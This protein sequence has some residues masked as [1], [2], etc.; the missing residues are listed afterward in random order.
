MKAVEPLIIISSLS[1][2]LFALSPLFLSCGADVSPVVSQLIVNVGDSIQN[3]IN[4]ALEG[5]TIL[6]KKGTYIEES[7]P[8]IVNKTVVIV[9][10]DVESTIVDGDG[11]EKG[12]FLVKSNGVKIANL[13]IRNTVD[14]PFIPVAGVQLDDVRNVMV[15][16]CKIEMCMAGIM[17]K[18]SNETFIVRNIITGN[19]WAGIYLRG[20]CIYNMIVGNTIS[21]NPCG[22]WIADLTC[23]Y[24]K[25]YHNNLLN[26]TSQTMLISVGGAWDNGYPSGG[27]YWSNYKGVDEK[28]GEYQ[29]LSGGDGIGDTPYEGLD[30]YPLLGPVHTFYAG[31][32]NNEN[33][34]VVI[35]SNLVIANFSFNPDAGPFIKFHVVNSV[36]G[37]GFC[38]II[39]P[40]FLLWVEKKEEW[41]VRVNGEIIEQLLID[42]SE[43]ENT[44]FYLTCNPNVQSIEIWGTKA[45]PEFSTMAFITFAIIL[46]TILLLH[47]EKKIC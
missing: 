16:N 46:P 29:N 1:V 18:D 42:E 36:G 14:N 32:W 3:A 17:L 5:A 7:Y 28:H 27:N 39:I 31:L 2:S 44:Y 41:S 35:S 20:Y 24:N 33:Y 45:I 13:T 11:T 9:G 15:V 8:I 12:V 10:E 40:R 43:T 19:R 22:V 30:N 4:Q 37:P 23:R 47:M 25:F 6:I 38:R 26:N 34:Y 21:D